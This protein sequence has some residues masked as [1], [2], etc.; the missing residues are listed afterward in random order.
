MNPSLPDPADSPPVTTPKILFASRTH[1]QLSQVL[2][3]LRKTVFGGGVAAYS[4]PGDDAR[5]SEG[6]KPVRALALGSRRNLCI[7]PA[8]LSPSASSSSSGAA[9]P[10]TGGNGLD[11][12]CLDL[13]STTH[14]CSFLPSPP[15]SAS[16]KNGPGSG[17][18]ATD[19]GR[20]FVDGA[21]A[22]V[23]D[24]EDL[25]AYGEEKGCCPYYGSR[26]LIDQAEVSPLSTPSPFSPT[27]IPSL[28]HALSRCVPQIIALPYNLILHSSARAT[29]NID[30][31]S[32]V[33]LIDE[34]HNLIDT[35]L[36]LHSVNTTD[37][38]LGLAKR[39]LETYLEKFSKRL[40]STN[41]VRLRQA[42]KV[43]GGLL[44]VCASYANASPSAERLLDVQTLMS[45]MGHALDQINLLDLASWLTES[46]M[47]VK[48][49]GY[50]EKLM[51]DEIRQRTSCFS[52]S[53]CRLFRPVHRLIC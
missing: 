15:P 25:R 40:K 47:A 31:A 42:L 27:R 48:V 33:L 4:P 24:I 8:V 17:L 51:D 21:F 37:R 7:N 10:N 6:M 53:S 20:A 34:A 3:E 39:Q 45:E 41:A 35:V 49:S 30:L 52:T 36:S 13:L 28:T 50:A 44:A 26:A 23:R 1:S 5:V 38:A 18:A 2:A 12:R 9:N 22:A 14:G 29:L 19:R 46:R 11:E 16:S 32:N 43:L